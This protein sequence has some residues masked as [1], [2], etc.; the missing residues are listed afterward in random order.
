[1]AIVNFNSISGVS[2]ISATSSITVGDVKLNPHSVAIGTT[3]TTG[4]NAGVSTAI[5]TL[6]FN[7]TRNTAQVY[8]GSTDGWVDFGGNE[9]FEATGGTKT[10]SGSYTIH[11]MTA[12]DQ[13]FVVTSGS[14]IIEVL[15][16]GGGGGTG[17]DVGGGGG[18]GALIY[19][20]NINATP[21]TYD[22]VIGSGG[23]SSQSP[24]VKGSP[25]ADTTAFG[26]TAAGGGG[27]GAYPDNGT[28]QPGGSGGGAGDN[29]YS[30]GPASGDPGGTANSVS[31]ASG[32]GNPGGSSSPASWGSGG[33]GGAGGSGSNG[34]PN[35]QVPGGA[36][37]P[38]SITG[39]SANYAGGGYGNSDAG[40][41]YATGN[42]TS[43]S[44]LGTYGYGA[45]GTGNP[46]GSPFSGNSGV[47]IVRYST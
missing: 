22:I 29:G 11:T 4:R 45:N 39:S 12:S 41:V 13:D 40:A 38:Y 7:T 42:D 30:G 15:I 8:T 37:L 25:G 5:G 23:A 27:G 6:I 24:G 18:A 44:P 32:W 26:F 2:T 35:S 36:S 34:S 9:L 33:G 14:K 43:N 16:V 17:W 20:N 47:V 19:S 3:D 28:G 31:P 10:T 21:G 1:M 46:N